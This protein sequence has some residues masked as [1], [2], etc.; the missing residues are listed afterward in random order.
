[1]NDPKPTFEELITKKIQ[2]LLDEHQIVSIREKQFEEDS[3]MRLCYNSQ[4]TSLFD[5]AWQLK[6]VLEKYREDRDSKLF[7]N[8]LDD[9]KPAISEVYESGNHGV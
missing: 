3:T 8:C 4:A 9:I 2:S 7:P 6:W 1:M 5:L